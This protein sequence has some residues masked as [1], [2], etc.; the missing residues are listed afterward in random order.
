MKAVQLMDFCRDMRN[1]EE[2]MWGA[3][4]QDGFLGGRILPF[5][6]SHNDGRPCVW[7]KVTVQLFFV[8]DI[9]EDVP[10]AILF[11]MGLRRVII[12][13]GQRRVMG[14]HC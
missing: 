8:D 9:P 7:A 6:A 2:S 12:P 10:G 14:I 5:S 4:L 1:A 11:P 13:E 3:S